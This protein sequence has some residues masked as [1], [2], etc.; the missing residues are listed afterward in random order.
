ML[1]DFIDEQVLVISLKCM[2]RIYSTDDLFN[3]LIYFEQV[4]SSRQDVHHVVL[5]KKI[6]KVPFVKLYEIGG[7]H[8]S[9]S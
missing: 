7:K 1:I 2:V 5:L 9:L 6:T 3:K 4:I 8:F